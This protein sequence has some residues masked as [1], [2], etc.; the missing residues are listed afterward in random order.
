MKKI[1]IIAALESEFFTPKGKIE[2]IYYTGIGK[3]NSA[4]ATTQL[5]LEEKPDLILNV[6]TA[7]CIHREFLGKVFG[8]HEVIDK[9]YDC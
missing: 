5:I 2:K 3:I 8:I 7:G 1:A 6:G 9:G 4:R